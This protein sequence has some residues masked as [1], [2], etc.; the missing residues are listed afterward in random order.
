MSEKIN[1]LDVE[2]DELTAKEALRE[3][4]RYMESEP[5]SIIEMVTVDA[6]MRISKVQNL[7]E[8]VRFFDLMLAEIRRYWRRQM[9]WSGRF[10][11]RQR[12]EHILSCLQDICTRTIKECICW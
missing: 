12:I 9:L 10:F 11:R 6:L 8:D 3:S 1:I 5:I 4:I 2:I 7:I